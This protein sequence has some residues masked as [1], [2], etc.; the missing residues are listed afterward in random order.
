[1]IKINNKKKK[2]A[3]ILKALLILIS[4]IF[5]L[6]FILKD[7]PDPIFPQQWSINNKSGIHV[8]DMWKFYKM[9]DSATV[10]VAIIDTGIDFENE[11]LKG[12]QWINHNEIPNNNIDDDNNGYI[13]DYNGWSFTDNTKDIIIDNYH[14]TAC[15]EII[16]AKHNSIGIEG[17]TRNIK[18]K[19]MS[20][21][22]LTSDGSSNYGEISDIVSAIKYAERNGAKICN[23][24]LSTNFYS[25]D[26]YDVIKGSNMLFV[27]SAGNTNVIRHINI[28]KKKL[29]PASYNLDNMIVVTGTSKDKLLADSSN[30]GE[31]TVDICAPG[32]EIYIYTNGDL[33]CVSGTSFA[34]PHV[35]GV[36]ATLYSLGCNDV[37]K[38]KKYILKGVDKND[39][40]KDLCKSGGTLN[41]R[42]SVK[43]FLEENKK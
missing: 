9:E 5:L 18:I 32:S 11:E 10:V 42:N 31:K 8:E 16:A 20:L 41:G 7:S 40:L 23:L 17:I 21:K 25:Q 28:D 14:G 43:L 37:Q 33:D 26:L 34:V 1:M 39:S 22:T 27:V 30:Y 29:Y 12:L 38:I 13:D 35:T 24:S 4:F 6:S 3:H 2:N 36:A 19:L 15:A